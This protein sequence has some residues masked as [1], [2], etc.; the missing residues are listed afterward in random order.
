[1]ILKN[2]KSLLRRYPVAVALNFAGLVCAFVAFALIALQ[3]NYEWSFDK[4]HPTADRVFRVAQYLSMLS[5]RMSACLFW[6]TSA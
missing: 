6:A 2:L 3:V 1:M 5:M 4:C